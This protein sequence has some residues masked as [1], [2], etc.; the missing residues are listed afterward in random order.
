MALL[1]LETLVIWILGFIGFVA[2]F[3]G[4]TILSMKLNNWISKKKS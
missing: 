3:L 1:S 4:V 2:I